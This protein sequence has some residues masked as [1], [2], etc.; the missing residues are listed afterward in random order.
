LEALASGLTAQSLKDLRIAI[1]HKWPS[2]PIL[3]LSRFIHGIEQL[4]HAAQVMFF[5]GDFLIFLLNRSQ[6]IYD[7]GVPVWFSGRSRHSMMPVGSALSAKLAA[8]EELYLSCDDL[9]PADWI[10]LRRLLGQCRS[11][12]IF[13]VQHGLAEIANSIRSDYAEPVPVPDPFPA[14]EE[15]KLRLI[16]YS[17]ENITESQRVSILEAFKPFA[18]AQQQAG[19]PIKVLWSVLVLDRLG[20]EQ[21][22]IW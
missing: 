11:V 20:E 9:C 16:K 15:I 17:A 14:L 12:R 13:K 3:H 7:P 21:E 10:E 8:V 22:Y 6:S 19:H 2:S 4:Y 1:D 18:A 5:G